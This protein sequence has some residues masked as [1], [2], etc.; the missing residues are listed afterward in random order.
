MRV[1]IP[2]SILILKNAEL[3]VTRFYRRD[4]TLRRLHEWA[5]NTKT[6]FQFCVP[7]PREVL[8]VNT[9]IPS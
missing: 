3:L 1:A 4:E 2:L 7:D 6:E 8:K 9:T 5:N